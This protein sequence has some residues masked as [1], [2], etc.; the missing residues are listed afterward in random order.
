MYINYETDYILWLHCYTYYHI[1]SFPFKISSLS[2]YSS[3]CDLVL[4]FLHFLDKEILTG[5]QTV[6]FFRR[7]LALKNYPISKTKVL[8]ITKDEN[9]GIGKTDVQTEGFGLQF[10]QKGHFS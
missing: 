8:K 1:G 10:S 6:R 3:T 2:D 5:Y 7:K 9:A 4:H